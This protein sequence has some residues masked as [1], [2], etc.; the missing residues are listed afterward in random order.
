VE[1]LVQE[2]S[3]GGKRVPVLRGV[4]LLVEQGEFICL[5]GPSGSGKSTLLNLI[6]GLDRFVS[7]RI[8]V[9]DY[10][11]GE[12]DENRLARY[13]RD[14]LG[15]IFQSYNLIP[16][17]RAID[18]VEMPLIFAGVD[19][20]QR[21][22]RAEEALALVG[23]E[24]RM[25]HRP[26]ELS[27]GE[28]QRVAVA[29]ALI[30]EPKLILGDEPTGNLDTK[31]GREILDLLKKLNRENGRTFIIVTHNPE[32]SEYADRILTLRDG[33]IDSDEEKK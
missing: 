21:R 14:H 2:F 11:L 31:T 6:G 32:V 26:I 27:G 13:R 5:F 7:G 28:Q 23:L 20:A 17:L 4:S 1:N 29:R 16:T 12:L 19:P 33:V 24:E 30:N 15:F 8:I 25:E 22:I 10:N 9:D 18:N 3:L